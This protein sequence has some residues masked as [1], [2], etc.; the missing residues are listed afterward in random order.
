MFDLPV[1]VI[2]G[3]L[4]SGKTT[5]INQRLKNADGIRYAV[6][7]NDFGD[8]NIDV[9]LIQSATAK[10]IS[11]MNGCVCCSI[12]SDVNVALESVLQIADDLD[13]VLLEASGVADSTRVKDQVLNWPG[14]AYND[15]VTLVDVTR[16]QRLVEDKYVGQH[17]RRQLTTSDQLTLTKQDLV[18]PETYSQVERWL[19]EYVADT[20]VSSGSH[21]PHPAFYTRT[22]TYPQ[23]I[24]RTEFERW[25]NN[26]D[27][28]MVRLKGFV[29]FNDNPRCCYLV[30]GVEETWKISEAVTCNETAESRIVLIMKQ[31][32]E[33]GP[34]RQE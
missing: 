17:V 11:L 5:Y 2:A 24:S 27:R 26:T 20:T 7:V 4:G 18:S 33:N 19:G 13:W 31:R 16:I 1:T 29:Y 32:H 8:L 9:D 12:A 25:L 21:E 34:G 23:P 3:Y 10:S 14:F 28:N 15:T 22:L 6:L 30:Q